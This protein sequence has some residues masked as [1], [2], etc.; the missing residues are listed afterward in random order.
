MLDTVVLYATDIIGVEVETS[1]FA[2]GITEVRINTS[3]GKTL[4]VRGVA[5]NWAEE[6]A[7][8]LENQGVLKKDDEEW[9]Q[10]EQT[11]WP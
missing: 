5:Y 9:G 3:D 4:R 10:E 7:Q 2:P 1:A 8:D 6:C 11:T